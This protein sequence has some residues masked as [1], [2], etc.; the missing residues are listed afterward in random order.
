MFFETHFHTVCIQFGNFLK[1]NVM[2][3]CNEKKGGKGSNKPE[4]LGLIKKMEQRLF[5]QNIY[6]VKKSTDTFKDSSLSVASIAV[7]AVSSSGC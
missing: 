3:E 1:K 4:V 6:L 2:K 7:L 5:C